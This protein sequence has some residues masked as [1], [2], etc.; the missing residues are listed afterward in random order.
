MIDATT[1][2]VSTKEPVEVFCHKEKGTIVGEWA[3]LIGGDWRQQV[4]SACSR[5][6]RSGEGEY[7]DERAN[8]HQEVRGEIR[9]GGVNDHQ[10]HREHQSGYGT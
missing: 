7:A 2:T 4:A 1:A 3:Q 9:P 6:G 8:E 10:E 5:C